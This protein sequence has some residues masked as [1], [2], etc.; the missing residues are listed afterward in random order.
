MLFPP[1]R[2]GVNLTCLQRLHSLIGIKNAIPVLLSFGWTSLL[3]GNTSIPFTSLN[4][5]RRPL[6]GLERGLSLC[7]L[8]TALWEDSNFS[9]Q[10]LSISR[11]LSLTLSRLLCQTVLFVDSTLRSRGNAASRCIYCLTLQ[12][13]NYLPY[14]LRLAKSF[15]RCW[16]PPWGGSTTSRT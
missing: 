13:L 8:L 7:D 6:T 11:Q 3:L 5:L 4:F 9:P 10:L 16:G 15:A 12:H 1:L 2:P 14:A